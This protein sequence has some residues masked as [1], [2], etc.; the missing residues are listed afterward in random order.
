MFLAGGITGCPDWQQ[1]M[2][3]LLADMPL[4]V[5]NPRRANFPLHDPNAAEAQIKWEHGYLR[6]ASAILFWFPCETLCPITLYELGAWTVLPKPI[7]IGAHPD[8]QR[9]QDIE[10]Q[11]ALV[12][13]EVRLALSLEALAQQIRSEYTRL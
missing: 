6:K 11:T 5:F 7:F 3:D 1:V 10:I 9:K 2:L 12:R 4:V 13:P 8:Y